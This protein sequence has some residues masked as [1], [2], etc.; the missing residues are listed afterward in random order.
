[1]G[2]RDSHHHQ[3]H[4]QDHP[5]SH[6]PDHGEPHHHAHEAHRHDHNL[7]AAYFHVLAD[8]LTSLLAIFALLAAKYFGAVWTVS[9]THPTLPT[10]DLV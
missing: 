1:M 6:D 3:A 10:S 7:R 9:Y 8:A 2:K 5:H 4:D